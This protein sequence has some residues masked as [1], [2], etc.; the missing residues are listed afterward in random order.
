MKR[1]LSK[2][3]IIIIVILS[4]VA[5]CSLVSYIMQRP[6]NAYKAIYAGVGV[7]VSCCIYG[8]IKDRLKKG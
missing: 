2:I 3:D 5:L 1:K 6:D 7:F 4:L 8:W